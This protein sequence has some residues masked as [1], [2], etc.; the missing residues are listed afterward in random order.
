MTILKMTKG[1]SYTLGAYPLTAVDTVSVVGA[2]NVAIW[3]PS[4]TINS[5]VYALDGDG[6]LQVSVDTIDAIKADTATWLDV[7][8][9]D[10]INTAATALRQVNISGTTKLTVRCQ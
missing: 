4:G 7:A 8:T 10:D 3:L 9:N 2:S 5:L 1:K 6:T